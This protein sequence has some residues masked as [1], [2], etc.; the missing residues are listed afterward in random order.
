MTRKRMLKNSSLV[1]LAFALLSACAGQPHKNAAMSLLHDADSAYQ[2][3]N[4]N[5]AEQAYQR[6]TH[7][8]PQDAYAF[9]KLGNTLAKQKR[10]DEAAAAYQAALVRDVNM[11]KAYNNLAMVRL[12]QAEF[13]LEATLAKEQANDK[14]AGSARKMLGMVQRIT[15]TP[16]EDASSPMGA[17]AA[18]TTRRDNNSIVPKRNIEPRS[19]S[20]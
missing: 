18:A 1:F 5:A 9:F 16:V 12:L 10:L 13:A 20:P 14:F 6:L 15:Q 7:L 3:G 11:A 19:I 17:P 4:W 2:N 8:V